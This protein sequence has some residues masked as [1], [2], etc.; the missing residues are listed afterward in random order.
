MYKA[1]HGSWDV[2]LQLTQEIYLHLSTPHSFATMAIAAIYSLFII[3]KSG[4]L[5]YYKV[6]SWA[7]LSLLFRVLVDLELLPEE[8]AISP[9]LWFS[10]EDGHQ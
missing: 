4:G 10:R 8:P 3:N 6:C 7:P 9:G 5:I 1:F 2:F